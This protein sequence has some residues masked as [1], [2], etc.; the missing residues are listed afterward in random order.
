MQVYKLICDGT[1][2]M[3]ANAALDSKKGVQQSL[4]D[5]LNYLTRKYKTDGKG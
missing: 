4:L 3:R 5:S 1:V 2:D